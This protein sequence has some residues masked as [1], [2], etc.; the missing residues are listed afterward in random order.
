MEQVV[1]IVSN[2]RRGDVKAEQ[3]SLVAVLDQAQPSHD[4]DPTGRN[5]SN[6]RSAACTHN[7]PA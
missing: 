2:G 1:Q 4:S 7:R 6:P 3:G 5:R